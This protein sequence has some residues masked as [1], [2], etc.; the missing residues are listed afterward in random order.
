MCAQ[1]DETVLDALSNAH[2]PDITGLWSFIEQLLPRVGRIGYQPCPSYR[3]FLLDENEKQFQPVWWL[4]RRGQWD[5]L[6]QVLLENESEGGEVN[7]VFCPSIAI[8]I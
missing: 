2:C 6:F 1:G 4:W 5:G 3:R 8:E 7:S